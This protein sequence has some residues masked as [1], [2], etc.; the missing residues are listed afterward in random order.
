MQ[1]R[2]LQ[3]R[4][5]KRQSLKM[6]KMMK[7]LP[8]SNAVSILII[9]EIILNNRILHKARVTGPSLSCCVTP[10]TWAGI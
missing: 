1:E 2:G 9:V 3:R 8:V 10:A 5:R 7:A 4:K 6:M